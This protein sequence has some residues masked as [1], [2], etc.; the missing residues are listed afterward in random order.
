[1]TDGSYHVLR[2]IRP[3]HRRCHPRVLRAGSLTAAHSRPMNERGFGKALI[4][5]V[6]E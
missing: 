1:M 4:R 6:Y 3:L 2:R 5:T